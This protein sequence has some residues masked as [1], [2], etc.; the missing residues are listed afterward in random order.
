MHV[1]IAKITQ[2]APLRGFGHVPLAMPRDT[3]LAESQKRVTPRTMDPSMT[4]PLIVK[5]GQNYA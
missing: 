1:C 5:S 3:W 2:R 4:I